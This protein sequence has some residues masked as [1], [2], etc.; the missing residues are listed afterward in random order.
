M[1]GVGISSPR[2]WVAGALV[3]TVGLVAGCGSDA[4]PATVAGQAGPTTGPGTTVVAPAGDPGESPV[5]GLD[6]AELQ[7]AVVAPVP[8]AASRAARPTVDRVALPDGRTVWRVRIPGTVPA[9]SARAT[10]SVGD[11]EIGVAVTPPDLSALVAVTTDGT[12]LVAGAPVTYRWEGAEAVAAG[13]LE[14]VA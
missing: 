6:A 14:V 10:I 1:G 12:G 3:A 11:R 5:D 13:A 2:R 8:P 7:A 4:G 9:R